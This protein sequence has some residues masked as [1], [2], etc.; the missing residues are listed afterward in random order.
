MGE[1]QDLATL[2]IYHALRADVSVIADE[3]GLKPGVTDHIAERAAK[4][5]TFSAD[6]SRRGPTGETVLDWVKR[7]KTDA[8]FYFVPDAPQSAPRARIPGRP[9][10]GRAIARLELANGGAR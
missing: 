8:P 7:L 1:P 6:G 4:L 3:A 2:A 5:F 9:G 10:D